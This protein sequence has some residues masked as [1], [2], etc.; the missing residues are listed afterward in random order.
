MKEGR[1]KSKGRFQSGLEKKTL[2]LETAAAD[3][4]PYSFFFFFLLA[5]L[6]V[7]KMQEKERKNGKEPVSRES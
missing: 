7:G 5:L 3:F 1:K 2:F 4:L 6:E